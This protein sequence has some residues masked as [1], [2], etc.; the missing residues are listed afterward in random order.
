M[1]ACDGC[2]RWFHI[3]CVGLTTAPKKDKK[4]FCKEATCQAVFLEYQ[5][6]KKASRTKKIAE[7]FD[8]LSQK[9][10]DRQPPALSPAVEEKLKAMEAEKKRLEEEMDAELLL[11]EKEME[12][13]NALKAR[14]MRMERELRE[15]ELEK[16]RLL[17]EKK[18]EEKEIQL[19]KELQE[20][21]DHLI[22]MKEMEKAYRERMSA[23]DKQLHKA[24]IVE[25]KKKDVTESVRPQEGP[26]GMSKPPVVSKLTEANLKL[27]TEREEDVSEEEESSD[28]SDEE[29][30]LGKEDGTEIT[31]ASQTGQRRT[32]PSKAQLS[33]RSGLTRKLPAFSGKPEEWPL[34]FGAYQAS[35]EAC[36][37][38]EVEN[39]VRL[40]DSLKGAALEAVRGQ[41]LL[42]KSVPRVIAKLRQLYGR[43]E[44]LLQSHLDK[45]RKLES[46]RADKLATFIPFGNAVEQ[47]CEHLEA[48]ELTLHLVNPILIQDLVSKLPDGEKRQWVQYKKKK[49]VV[50]LRTFTDFVAGIVS[51]AC[52]A[53]VS[54]DYKPDARS[55]A[56]A[57]GRSKPAKEKGA[58][59]SHSEVSRS[60]SIAPERRKQKPCRVCQRED[61]RLRF[62]QDFRDLP[63]ADRM[64]AP[65][66][67]TALSAVIIETNVAQLPF[68]HDFHSICVR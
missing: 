44:Q 36:G 31:S 26:S 34:F 12:M 46:P 4:W 68:G 29:S 52:E 25:C 63:Y 22:R 67:K 66:L 13:K 10:S 30:S 16:D 62:C 27:L 11:R 23:V 3:R 45:V 55:T 43:P 56:G 8:R 50:T 40:Q 53:N 14:R 39:L 48:A 38:T 33:A 57:S 15:K 1:I 54:F 59:Y 17:R 51:D 19:Q 37:Y 49:K 41:L 6:Q 9:S 42:P 5:K 65:N 24:E 35:N 28:S 2:D 61:H 32:G 58:L 18:I 47:L 64:N 60:G 7:E 20:K 21:E